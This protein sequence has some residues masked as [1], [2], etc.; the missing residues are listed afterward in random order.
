[1][2]EGDVQQGK[3]QFY[4]SFVLPQQGGILASYRAFIM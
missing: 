2:Y 3:W 1:M 4:F